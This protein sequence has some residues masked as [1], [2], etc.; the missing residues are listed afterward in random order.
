MLD[1]T[2]RLRLISLAAVIVALTAVLAAEV[3]YTTDGRKITGTVTRDGDSVIVDTDDGEQIVLAADD[4]VHIAYLPTKPDAG[5]DQDDPEDEEPSDPVE[6]T[7]E[8]APTDALPRSGFEDSSGNVVPAAI[9]FSMADAVHPESIAF[10]LM[11]RVRASPGNRETLELRQQID[12]WQAAS[13]DRLRRVGGSWIKPGEFTIRRDKYARQ[14]LVVRNAAEELED[15]DD[16]VKAE[17]LSESDAKLKRRRLKAELIREM[18]HAAAMWADPA[19][20]SFLEGITLYREEDWESALTAFEK[21]REANPLVAA[22]HQGAALAMMQ[23]NGRELD[24]LATT[25]DELLLHP[26]DPEALQRVKYAMQ[27]T[28]GHLT[29]NEQFQRADALVEAYPDNSTTKRRSRG[30]QWQMPGKAGWLVR[31]RTLPDPPYD[32]IIVRQAA[33]VPVAE[34]VLLV[35][36]EV[37]DGALE[38]FVR[39]DADTMA[40]A[41]VGRR[42]S[43]ETDDTHDLALIWVVGYVF[44]PV[45]VSPDAVFKPGDAAEAFGVNRFPEMGGE[46]RNVRSQLTL[47]GAGLRPEQLLAPGESGSAVLTSDRRLAGY[48][49]ART[50]VL[51]DDGGEGRFIPQKR[52]CEAIAKPTTRSSTSSR[53]RSNQRVITWRQADGDAFVVYGLFGEKLD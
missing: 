7:D 41:L 27:R 49:C 16:E 35:D 23:I 33:G 46:I 19:V 51:E 20:R 14:L 39:I 15:V 26:E 37:V 2:R 38:V 48:L 6:T 28:P 34:N 22:Y 21:A 42:P 3:V 32:R 4:V 10:M 30:F 40:V 43:R 45:A 36:R 53:R 31:D 9:T 5:D 12:H 29:E 1:K 13:H 52:F 8:K 11:R 50:E 18:K 17:R 47:D 44:S 24:A 25:L